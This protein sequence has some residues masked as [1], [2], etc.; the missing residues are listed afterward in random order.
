MHGQHALARQAVSALRRKTGGQVPRG[1]PVTGTP[2]LTA[3]CR[4]RRARTRGRK[5]AER[6]VHMWRGD[7]AGLQGPRVEALP[8]S[9]GALSDKHT[10]C[11]PCAAAV[12][13][14]PCEQVLPPV[15]CRSRVVAGALC[16]T[17][18]NL[19]G[20]LSQHEHLMSSLRSLQHWSWSRVTSRTASPLLHLVS[21][22]T[23]WVQCCPA[24]R[25]KRVVTR[26]A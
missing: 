7:S 21:Q 3:S 20:A 8:G 4:F 2:L 15:E 13:W 17:E 26:A 19:E 1:A 18:L 14:Q 5:G 6:A 22:G 9:L 23:V 24:W 16:A 10:R 11:S 25:R 12:A